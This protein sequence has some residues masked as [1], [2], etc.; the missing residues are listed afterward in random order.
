MS[1]RS[2]VQS[3]VWSLFCTL[4]ATRVVVLTRVV[5]ATNLKVVV[6]T[7]TKVVE[8]TR[9]VAAAGTRVV[10]VVVKINDVEHC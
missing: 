6:A 4:T 2:W 1:R 9:V 10:V 3:P 8:L 5:A 7:T